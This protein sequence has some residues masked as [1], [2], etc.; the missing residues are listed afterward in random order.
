MIPNT[1]ESKQY[2]SF[3]YKV[4][5]TALNLKLCLVSNSTE[6]THIAIRHLPNPF[7]LNGLFTKT[8]Q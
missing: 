1:N 7:D 4:M 5:H 6:N 8:L 3:S 2:L